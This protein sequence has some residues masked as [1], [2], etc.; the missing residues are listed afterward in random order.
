[1]ISTGLLTTRDHYPKGHFTE[2]FSM[3]T[4]NKDHKFDMTQM[5]PKLP[6]KENQMR[7]LKYQLDK[8]DEYDDTKPLDNP[9]A[10]TQRC[11]NKSPASGGNL[12]N[13][14]VVKFL[15][16]YDGK[17]DKGLEEE[18]K[19]LNREVE[20]L[21]ESLRSLEDEKKSLKKQLRTVFESSSPEHRNRLSMV[22]DEKDELRRS[23]Q[24]LKY[25]IERLSIQ[26][27]NLTEE[28]FDMKRRYDDLK[29]CYDTLETL[30]S[31]RFSDYSIESMPHSDIAKSAK[32]N[33][34]SIPIFGQHGKSRGEDSSLS[35]I[36][37][38]AEL[39]DLS[40]VDCRKLISEVNSFDM[41]RVLNVLDS[42][43]LQDKEP[44][45]HHRLDP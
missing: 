10:L 34:D 31:N 18:N 5:D 2:M 6:N 12:T 35:S 11:T 16:D 45:T 43:H 42:G 17:M 25:E 44:R 41:H 29:S 1:M 20:R 32:E 27:T 28:R 19:S 40:F 26:V 30:T 7:K 14:K 23:N 9:S 21:R 15:K 8:N 4:Q 39:N 38:N 13:G 36:R 22:D 3:T 33:S 37:A 24:I